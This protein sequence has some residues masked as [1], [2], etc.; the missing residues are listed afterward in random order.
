MQMAR[1]VFGLGRYGPSGRVS[2]DSEMAV[3]D[4][5]CAGSA[6]TR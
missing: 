6:T 3:A 5:V 2:S 1:A 4:G